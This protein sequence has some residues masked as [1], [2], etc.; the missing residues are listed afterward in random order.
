MENFYAQFYHY[1]TPERPP[2]DESISRTEIAQRLQLLMDFA[3]AVSESYFNLQPRGTKI[4]RCRR[5]EQAGWNWIYRDELKPPNSLSP[6][7][8]K[9]AD[10]IA[11]E[12]DLRM[13]HM[14]IVES[15]VEVTGSY[16]KDKP[17]IDR[18]AEVTL[19]LWDL[20]A[21]IK[22][23]NPSNRPILG[24]RR[25]QMTISNPIPISDYWDRYKSCRSEAKQAVVDLTQELQT[26]LEGTIDRE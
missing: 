16:V 23:D 4:D 24:K 7:G 10:R 20:V 1:E 19:L 18:F 25:V 12:S 26:S 21:R 11:T 15:F 13:W 5:I 6:I 17:T 2:L 9:L 22:G 14:R 8:Q 3:L